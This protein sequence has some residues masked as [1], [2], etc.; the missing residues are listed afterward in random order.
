MKLTRSAI[1][2][3]VVLVFA[4]GIVLGAFGQR[5][6]TVSVV[7]AKTTR[8]PEEFRKTYMTEMKGRLKLTPEQVVQLNGILDGT[9][10]RFHEARERLKPE[11]DTIRKEQQDKVRAMLKPE[12]RPEYDKMRQEREERERQTG[13][14]HGL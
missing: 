9:R 14:G 11:L 6:Y 8:N 10:A 2:L 12:Q 5:L 3:Y 7:S 4:S 1:T 13:A